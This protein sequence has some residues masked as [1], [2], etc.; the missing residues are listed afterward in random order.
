MIPQVLVDPSPAAA[1]LCEELSWISPRPIEAAYVSDYY[2]VKNPPTSYIATIANHPESVRRVPIRNSIVVASGVTYAAVFLELDHDEMIEVLYGAAFKGVLPIV[3]YLL[4][5]KL[6]ATLHDVVS[7]SLS[8][9]AENGH[10]LTVRYLTERI[11]DQLSLSDTD[12]LDCL[13]GTID[14]LPSFIYVKNRLSVDVDTRVVVDTILETGGELAVLKYNI[15]TNNNTVNVGTD[16]VMVCITGGWFDLVK[17]ITRII[18]FDLDFIN[19][20]IDS[21]QF[22]ILRHLLVLIGIT[23]DI[24]HRLLLTCSTTAHLPTG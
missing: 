24:K 10:L 8:C 2:W 7:P 9:A 14:D 21:R 15:M 19:A 4:E 22:A 13:L 17:L 3:M 23:D 16:S 6:W 20:A 1:L 5:V 12:R 11:A 18:P